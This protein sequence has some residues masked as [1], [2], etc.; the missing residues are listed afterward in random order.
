MGKPKN[1]IASISKLM[2]LCSSLDS[3]EIICVI[4]TF[5]DS[6]F[7]HFTALNRSKKWEVF[8]TQKKLM[9]KMAQEPVIIARSVK[10]PPIS[11]KLLD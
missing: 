8:F 3:F 5:T 1:C 7:W 11:S 9:K 10:T 4:K 2:V 6:V